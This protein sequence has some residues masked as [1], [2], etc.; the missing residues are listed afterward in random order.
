MLSQIEHNAA[1]AAPAHR[2]AVH[3]ITVTLAFLHSS[4][5]VLRRQI[6]PATSFK[7][8]PDKD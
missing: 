5:F 6:S 7:R 1:P 8:M 4:F 3:I 2:Y